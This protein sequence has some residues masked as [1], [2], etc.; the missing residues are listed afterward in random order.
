MVISATSL[1]ID[2]VVLGG[3]ISAIADSDSLNADIGI[4]EGF[5]PLLAVSFGYA[6][7]DAPAKEHTI[8]V[9]RV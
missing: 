5:A 2:S 1:G 8:T 9:N 6:L 4:P 3:P 7:E